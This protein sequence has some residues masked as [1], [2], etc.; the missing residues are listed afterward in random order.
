MIITSLAATINQ[1][2][3]LEKYHTGAYGQVNQQRWSCC[4]LANRD[5]EGCHETTTPRRMTSVEGNSTQSSEYSAKNKR[6]TA[7]S[8][9]NCVDSY[10]PTNRHN[11]LATPAS[12]M[13]TST[14]DLTIRE[15]EKKHV[16]LVKTIFKGDTSKLE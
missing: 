6:H 3:M 7:E 14:P 15:S 16:Q 5:L 1:N 12:T 10:T 8:V 4:N 2:T 11:T 9:A 13:K